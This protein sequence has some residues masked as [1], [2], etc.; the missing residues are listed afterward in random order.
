MAFSTDGRTLASAGDNLIEL[1]NVA[2]DPLVP[3]PLGPALT[4]ST[5]AV[6]SLAFSPNGHT[7]ASG[8]N[9]GT[10]RLWS[11]ADHAHPQVLDPQLS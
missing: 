3:P 4:S 5:G 2:V 10:I 11:I 6:Y 9:D 1:W 7:L 8:H